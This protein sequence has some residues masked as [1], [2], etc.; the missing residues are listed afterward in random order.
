MHPF[1]SKRFELPFI[2]VPYCLAKS[3]IILLPVSHNISLTQQKSEYIWNEQRLYDM[4]YSHD[5][6]KC[7]YNC[8]L[9][10]SYI[11]WFPLKV[12]ELLLLSTIYKRRKFWNREN[13]RLPFLNEL[14]RFGMHWIWFDISLE[15]ICLSV[16]RTWLLRKQ[17][18]ST[19]SESNFCL[20]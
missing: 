19:F 14:T 8:L 11:N 16:C 10:D 17:I 9:F 20:I 13:F 5:Y 1:T 2:Y 7:C 12:L 6:L 15:N 4:S 18:C 3:G